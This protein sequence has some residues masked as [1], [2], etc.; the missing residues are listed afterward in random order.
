[1]NLTYVFLFVVIIVIALAIVAIIKFFS[2][3]K[4]AERED[5]MDFWL[6]TRKHTDE[7]P[8][9]SSFEEL[10][11]P[12]FMN[13]DIRKPDKKKYD[14][15]ASTVDA[16]DII[17]ISISE[18]KFDPGT[19][20]SYVEKVIGQR[21]PDGTMIYSYYDKEKEE[22][23]IKAW[24]ERQEQYKESLEKIIYDYPCFPV[25]APASGKV[26][27]K[28]KVEG[29]AVIK[30]EPILIIESMKMEI[31][32]VSPITGI[33]AKINCIAGQYVDAQEE[34]AV[35]AQIRDIDD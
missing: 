27:R 5:E 17:N 30:N 12:N 14:H 20:P 34:L 23:Q 33:V 1:M 11:M 19:V 7:K 32:C 24:K 2:S 26:L 4:S 35:V 9:S 28:L 18:D 31:K 6:K 22:E 8:G 29:S 15:K 10:A 25:A 21:R 13:F 16:S 3:V